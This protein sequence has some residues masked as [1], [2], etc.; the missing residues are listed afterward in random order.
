MRVAIAYNKPGDAAGSAEADVLEQ[1]EAVETALVGAGH[2]V[3]ALP[4]TLDLAG[5]DGAL[6]KQ[7]PDVVFNLVEALGGTDR[8]AVLVTLLLDAR[9]VP[10]TGAGSR[11]LEL[12]AD[13]V[14]AKERMRRL[15]LP[16]PDWYVCEKT[17]VDFPGAGCYIV[18]ARFEH[19]SLGLDD[20]SVVQ[21][22]D[23]GQLTR[24]IRAR[25]KHSGAQQFAERYVA[26]REFNVAL[27]AS[28]TGP[29]QVLPPAEIDFSA[30]APGKPRIV[31]HDAKWS[32][33]AFE[34]HATPRR[35]D[36]PAADARLLDLLGT[37]GMQV[38]ECFAMRGCARVDF[39][40]DED[41]RPWI[42]EINPNPCLSPDAGFAAALDAAGIPAE[43]MVGRLVRTAATD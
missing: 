17:Q 9:G 43:E 41:G 22:A 10:Y 23:A 32:S 11:A 14:G 5:F 3:C 29:A 35:F 1:V 15:G 24:R 8:L 34:Y 7:R 16:T 30:F 20:Q 38:W 2:Q 4:C 39:R 33:R 26:G 19:A 28:E 40:V 12:S 13:K 18:K 31:G 42:L 27:L 25:G 21:V 36:F 37:L 6:A